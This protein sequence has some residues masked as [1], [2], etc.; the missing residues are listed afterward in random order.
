[1]NQE[2]VEKGDKAEKL[3]ERYLNEK[4][5]P[6]YRIDQQQDTKSEE[7]INRKIRR[8]D[9]LIHT[10]RGIFYIDVKY[11]ARKPFGK[12]NE[13][14]FPVDQYNIDSS[15]KFHEE[16]HQE[17]WFAF[18]DNLD[19]PQ[20]YFS[21]ISHIHEYYENILRIYSEGSGGASYEGLMYIPDSLLLFDK[22]SIEKGFYKE[23]DLEY[24]KEEVEYLKGLKK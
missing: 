10:R 23:P 18:T 14:R 24:L 7:L 4:N 12:N 20:F 1:M 2:N 13:E 22:L 8:P 3:F 5:I 21:N 11:R 16:F 9:Y 17:V 6:F 19:T 15:Y